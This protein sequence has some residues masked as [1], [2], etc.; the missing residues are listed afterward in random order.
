MKILWVFFKSCSFYSKLQIIKSIVDLP[1]II[2]HEICH[3]LMALVL[4]VKIRQI[5]CDYFYK[6]ENNTLFAYS[7][8]VSSET[9]DTLIGA[10]KRIL[11]NAAPVIGLLVLI[12]FLF[13]SWA[14][15]YVGFSLKLF[16]LS[17]QDIENII[18]DFDHIKKHIN[19]F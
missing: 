8:C 2:F 6:I 15:L 19:I 17:K 1:A 5:R 9:K 7:F 18:S 12:Y 13:D 16:L 3:V 4:F 14:L 11:I 10:L